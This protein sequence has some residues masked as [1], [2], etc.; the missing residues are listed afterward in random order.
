M[1]VNAMAKRGANFLRYGEDE[2]GM[3]CP[4]FNRDEYPSSGA[5]SAVL[6]DVGEIS[7]LSC[8]QKSE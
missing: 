6:S 3:A 2:F 7:I 1:P 5:F 4:M 8:T